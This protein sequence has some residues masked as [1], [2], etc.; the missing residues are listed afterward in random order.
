MTATDAPI[1]RPK[2]RLARGS[3][4]GGLFMTDGEL[5]EMLGIP[6]KVARETIRYLD[7]RPAMGFPRKNPLWADRRYRPAVEAWL[8]KTNGHKIAS[9]ALV[10]PEEG[11]NE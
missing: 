3:K 1:A 9:P 4:R 8:A 11:D 10:G 6:E 2:R 7:A 5:V